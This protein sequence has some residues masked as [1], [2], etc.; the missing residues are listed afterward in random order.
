MGQAVVE[1]LLW[2]KVA[3]VLMVAMVL[4]LPASA[5]VVAV[6]RARGQPEGRVPTAASKF[7]TLEHK[8]EQ[9]RTTIR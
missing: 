4:P 3:M 2:V 5:A 7:G 1:I 9:I 6:Q 8:H